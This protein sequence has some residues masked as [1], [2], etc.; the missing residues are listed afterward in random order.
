MEE[1]GAEEAG[2]EEAKAEEAEAEPKVQTTHNRL[3]AMMA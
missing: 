1:T 3:T 2:M